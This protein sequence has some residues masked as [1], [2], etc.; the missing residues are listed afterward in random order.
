[1]RLPLLALLL[2]VSAAEACKVPV[3]RYALERWS[4]DD[5]TLLYRDEIDAP[6]TEGCNVIARHSPGLESRFAARYPDSIDFDLPPFWTGDDPAPLLSS[7]LRQLLV[8]RLAAGASTIW[9]LIEGPDAAQNDQ[10]AARLSDLLATAA[11]SI[12]IPEGVVRP[13]QLD[14]GEVA[15]ADIDVKDVLRSPIPLAI[16]FQI[17]RLAFDD[18]AEAGFRKMLQGFNGNP[19]VRESTGP[20]LVPVFGRGRMLEPLPVEMLNQE[21]VSMASQYLCGECSCELKDENPGVD[22]L[23]RADWETIL[24]NSYTIIDQQLPPLA[25]AGEFEEPVA[26]IATSPSADQAQGSPLSRNLFLLALGG[27]VALTLFSAIILR[28]G[29]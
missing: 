21:T 6:D 5:Y 15:L 23:L 2:L 14:T 1:M 11:E 17:L 28:S 24:S 19:A 8:D 22:L 20:L 16:D 13:E 7:P 3:F 29:T 4:S 25:G 12:A 18:T 10:I 26:E 27:V 9:V